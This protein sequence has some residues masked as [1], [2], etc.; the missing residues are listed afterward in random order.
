MAPTKRDIYE[1]A[2]AVV[3]ALRQGQYLPAAY[4]IRSP[5]AVAKSLRSNKK[6]KKS[7]T[8][9]VEQYRDVALKGIGRIIKGDGGF[10]H[11]QLIDTEENLEAMDIAVSLLEGDEHRGLEVD[12][13]VGDALRADEPYVE[14]LIASAEL[15][16]NAVIVGDESQRQLDL[17]M[18]G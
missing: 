11:F 16:K 6:L 2:M 10:S 12:K 9:F 18:L 4:A 1:K 14:S 17:L 13:N 7:T 3:A 8:E 5:L 15:R